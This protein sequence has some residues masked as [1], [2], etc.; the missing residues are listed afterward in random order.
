V[1]GLILALPWV[2]KARQRERRIWYR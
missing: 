2:V 1:V